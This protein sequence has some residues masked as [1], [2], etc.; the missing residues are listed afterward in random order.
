MRRMDPAN[1][2]LSEL[3]KILGDTRARGVLQDRLRALMRI[4]RVFAHTDRDDDQDAAPDAFVGARL[5]PRSPLRG[6]AIAIP[7]PEDD[8]ICQAVG[9]RR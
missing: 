5:R 9:N 6:S 4:P 2:R 8:V 7:E 1:R 3:E